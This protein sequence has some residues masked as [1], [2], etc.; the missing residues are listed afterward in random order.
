MDEL[1]NALPGSNPE[2]FTTFVPGPEA[3]P[4]LLYPLEVLLLGR[5]FPSKVN[6]INNFKI[7]GSSTLAFSLFVP[8]P[9]NDRLILKE[10]KNVKMGSNESY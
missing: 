8:G 9:A 10:I 2:S 6:Y 4:L 3:V 7:P 5:A 1:G